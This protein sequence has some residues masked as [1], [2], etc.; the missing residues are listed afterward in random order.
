MKKGERR[1]IPVILAASIFA[2]L[3]GGCASKETASSGGEE[4]IDFLTVWQGD[5]SMVPDDQ[6]NNAIAKKIR[7]AT[8]VT[9]N[10]ITNNSSE[11]EKLNVIFG[12][13]EMPDLISG[14]MWGGGDAATQLFKKAAKEGLLMP[15]DDLVEKYGPNVKPNLS[16]NLTDDF[17]KYDVE[18]P[19]FGGKHYF[20]TGATPVDEVRDNPNSNPGGFWIRKDIFDKLKIDRDSINNS[21]DLYELLKKIKN[22]HFLDANGKEIIPGGMMHSGEGE[23]NYYKSYDCN[24]MTGYMQDEN[25]KTMDVFYSDLLDKTILFMRRLYQEELVDKEALSQNSSQATEKV[26]AGKYGIVPIN[27]NEL[28]KITATTLDIT[29]PEMQ[30]IPLCSAL[31]GPSGKRVSQALNGS[32]GSAVVCMAKTTKKAEACMKVLNY[33]CGDEGNTLISYGI[34]GVHWEKNENGYPRLTEEWKQKQKQDPKLLYQEGIGGIYSR[35]GGRALPKTRYGYTPEEL[36][37]DLTQDIID[38][39]EIFNR[40]W[41]KEYINGVKVNYFENEYPDIDYIRMVKSYQKMVEARQKGY[42]AATEEEALS[43]TNDLRKQ[44]KDVGIE[45]LWAFMDE[46]VKGEEHLIY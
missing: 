42:F 39:S 26:A 15:L 2:G 14:P 40:G 25:G 43:Y 36:Q 6:I 44:I 22:E 21:E 20:I 1:V 45:K 46:K 12:S 11:T 23:G 34:E 18:D 30:Y 16:E 38:A 37:A 28:K 33:L 19:E 31:P 17:R 4:T 35:L 8:G 10:I 27:A 9:I 41:T 13:G 3:A 7:E 5:S 29:N 24:T 32:S